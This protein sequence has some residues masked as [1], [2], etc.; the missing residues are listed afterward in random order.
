LKN[1]NLGLADGSVAQTTVSA[2][3]QALLAATN[4]EPNLNPFY[5]FPQ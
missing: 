3:Q 5:N 2:L 1:G 4:G